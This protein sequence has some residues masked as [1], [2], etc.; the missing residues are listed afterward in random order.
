M[1]PFFLLFYRLTSRADF[2][3]SDEAAV[4]NPFHEATDGWA[5][6]E[7]RMAVAKTL[8]KRCLGNFKV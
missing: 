2:Q 6:A 5:S 7:Y 8:A 4:R 1:F 3:S